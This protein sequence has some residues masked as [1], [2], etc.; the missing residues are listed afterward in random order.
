M[1]RARVLFALIFAVLLWISQSSERLQAQSGQWVSTY[2]AGW[3]QDILPPSAIDYTA[4]THIIHFAVMVNSDGSI[5]STGNSTDRANALALIS[6][7]HP[8][9]TKVIVCVGGAG[10]NT[11]FQDA[12]ASHM[13]LVTHNL[14]QLV[15]S[16]GYDG[17]DIDWEPLVPSD[18]TDYR[19]LVNVL[20]D[21]LN[22]IS[23]TLVLTT[24]GGE[25]PS[26]KYTSIELKLD[27]INI[28]TYDMSGVWGDWVT[29]FNTALYNGGYT[30]PGH[31][32]EQVPCIDK[33]VKAWEAIG[34]SPSKL[35]IGWEFGGAV[36]KGGTRADTASQGVDRPRQ[37][38]SSIPSVSFDVYYSTIMQNYYRDSRYRW[39]TVVQV[40]YLTIDTTGSANDMFISY[41]DEHSCQAKINY[42]KTNG[43][44][45]AIIFDLGS[46]YLPASFSNRDRL[47]QAVKQ[48]FFGTTANPPSAPV[49][50][51]PADGA[52]GVAIN[53]T[54]SWNASTGATS[55]RVQV[56][57]SPAFPTTIIDRAGII[58]TSTAVTG[59]S[60]G[61]T[62][63]WQVNVSNIGG[64]SPWSTTSN[65]TTVAPLPPGPVLTAPPN[66]TTLAISDVSLQWDSISG[67]AS[68]QLQIA[69][70]SSFAQTSVDQRIA[71]N[72][73]LLHEC[74]D[75]TLYYWRVRAFTVSDTSNWSPTDRFT[76]QLPHADAIIQVLKAWNIVSVPVVA[77]NWQKK[78]IFPTAL[79]GAFAY[80]H[81]GYAIKDTLTS[82]TGY[83]MKFSA[84]Q[85]VPMRGTP[86]VQETVSVA[87][88]WNMI[89]SIAQRF[90]AYAVEQIPAAIVAS[91][92]YGFNRGYRMSDTIEPGKGY[93]VRTSQDGRLILNPASSAQPKAVHRDA[94]LQFNKLTIYDSEHNEADL[95]FGASPDK[96]QS[97]L[98]E[99]PP[100]LPGVFDV[101]FA[102]GSLLA[103]FSDGAQDEIPIVTSS[104][105]TPITIRWNIKSLA[106][107]AMLVAG[108]HQ[109]N[110]RDCD[111]TQ[112][113]D[114]GTHIALRLVGTQP[115]DF[116]L[117]ECF[118][119]P[120][121]PTATVSFT[122]VREQFISLKIYSLLGSE[123][124]ALA[125]QRMKAGTYSIS[126]RGDNLP[127]GLYF[128]N[129]AGEKSSQTRKLLLLK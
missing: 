65:F 119:N 73:F 102:S 15:L 120:F 20:R 89:G 101:R 52:T 3:N 53:P 49:L 125:N 18:S 92:F 23:D 61:L 110:L 86:L 60:R 98:Y 85:F 69:V 57:N 12:T 1:I 44:G 42:I 4:M 31:P 26:F 35:G 78:A 113:L 76:F 105:S 117:N 48:A 114:A 5:D 104:P 9:G 36:W 107:L 66:G 118:P 108:T 82:G 111:S 32:H 34:V 63:Y 45:G 10:D 17:V 21:S 19:N 56:S 67:A 43:L 68:Y 46:G 37:S 24:A 7:A 87:A 6:G 129:L 75:T 22:T 121:N 122:V 100:P 8:H 13:G 64:T 116:T 11:G 95:Y 77:N 55:Y 88:G 90:P 62:Y 81:T 80:S 127:S 91:D 58:S 70:D 96:G 124:A 94:L 84:D 112:I 83:W 99:L 14:K 106:P 38:W 41:D 93:W 47:L 74:C 25:S 97:R 40:P 33:D 51:S 16:R 123:V 2:Y 79:S 128:C 59:L 30:F 126:F 72:S 109:F 27:Q 71:G 54:L 29:W 115:E 50:A 39:D 103:V 28:M